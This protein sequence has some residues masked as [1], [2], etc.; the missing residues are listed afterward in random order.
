MKIGLVIPNFN[1]ALGGAEE[2]TWQFAA[3]LLEQR[4]EVHVLATGFS[5]DAEKLGVIPH[6]LPK[7]RSRRR[8]AQAAD[9]ALRR[10]PLDVT[11]DMGVGWRCDVF[12]PHGG[13]RR[14]AFEQNQL[15][16]PPWRRPIKR[17]VA[18][19]LPRYREF[20]AIVRRQYAH[21][22]R[23]IVA[24]SQMVADH[25]RRYHRAGDD[26]LRLIYN[27]VDT[28]RFQP[29]AAGELRETTRRELG[30]RDDQLLV[31]IVAHNFRLK[32]VPA[33]LQAIGAL[34]SEGVAA[35]LAVV[36]GKRLRPYQNL[37]RRVGAAGAV[38]FLGPKS[39]VA[40][41]YAAAD[42]Y[43][44]PTF[45][46]PCSL[47]LLE[48]LACGLP[49]ITSQYN[50]AGELIE[51]GEQGFIVPDPADWRTLA[52][53]IGELAEPGRRLAAGKSA[54][55]LAEEHTCQRNFREIFG[56]YEQI[57]NSRPHPA[58]RPP[59]TIQTGPTRKSTAHE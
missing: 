34:R 16:L 20:E 55:R 4:H 19:L 42:V 24:L 10:L 37:A 28:Q 39:N 33:L 49:V 58:M 50:G 51:D 22:G 26:Q 15:L 21:D 29:D 12:Q 18:P 35:H 53:R 9:D 59:R 32:G 7:S 52:A 36:G 27:G 11:H 43:A 40:P 5:D 46:D 8:V 48:A 47:V 54:R 30:L 56:L 38:S 14:A 6:R 23:L 31:L 41:Y 44:Q 57:V 1:R 3:W 17:A 45:Y 13:S 25:M 2:W